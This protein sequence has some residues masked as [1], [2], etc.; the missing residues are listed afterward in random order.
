MLRWPAEADAF[1]PRHLPRPGPRHRSTPA[2][3][4]AGWIDYSTYEQGKALRS[5]PRKRTD[6]CRGRINTLSVI[7]C[8]GQQYPLHY[9][10]LVLFLRAFSFLSCLVLHYPA[11]PLFIVHVLCVMMP[12]LG[13]KRCTAN[14]LSL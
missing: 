12:L 1:A 4:Q 11:P 14:G 13:V 2:L 10:C 7:P 5:A 9:L 3:A 6:A 8:A